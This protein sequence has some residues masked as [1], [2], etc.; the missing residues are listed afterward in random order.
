M[1]T[2]KVATTSRAALR[3]RSFTRSQ[4][5]KALV[6]EEQLAAEKRNEARRRR[7]E[8]T[9]HELY[10]QARRERREVLLAEREASGRPRMQARNDRGFIIEV[11]DGHTRLRDP[12]DWRRRRNQRYDDAVNGRIF[13]RD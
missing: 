8:P 9:P 13:I 4:A 2:K 5:R 12:G 3:T 10:L 7:G 1:A 11:V 6:R